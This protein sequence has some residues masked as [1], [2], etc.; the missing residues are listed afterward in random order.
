MSWMDF[1]PYTNFHEIN[2]DWLI[3]TMQELIKSWNEYKA[4]M[5]L[6]FS[7]LSD[8]FSALKTYVNT[9]FDELDITSEI[10][11]IISTY[12]EDGTMTSIL[13]S[14]FK[15]YLGV[16]AVNSNADMTDPEKVYVISTD[17]DGY[18]WFWDGTQFIKSSIAY[19]SPLNSLS[20]STAVPADL[21][22]VYRQVVR[23]PSNAISTT[24][25]T[26]DTD[27]GIIV[28]DFSVG[29]TARLQLA[30]NY[31]ISVDALSF[32]ERH[33]QTDTFTDWHTINDD[34][35]KFLSTGAPTDMNDLYQKVAAF[36]TSELANLTNI[37]PTNYGFI[38]ADFSVQNGRRAQFAFDFASATR[39][40]CIYFRTFSSNNW[41][42]W[43]NINAFVWGER[44]MEADLSTVNKEGSFYWFT[45]EAAN[46]A[47]SP[48]PKIA[49]I[50]TMTV[51]PDGRA[52]Q[53]VTSWGTRWGSVKAIRNRQASSG[54][55]PA[56][57]VIRDKE[58]IPG[59]GLT[60]IGD[61]MSCGYIQSSNSAGDDFYEQSWPAYYARR[62][63][64]PFYTA[65]AS[66][67]STVN[68]LSE[69]SD[70][71]ISK[72]RR[73]PKTQLYAVGLGIN[74]YNQGVTQA[75]FEANYK[76][77]LDAIFEKNPNAIVF[78]LYHARTNAAAY[79]TYVAN[80]VNAYPSNRVF[81]IDRVNYM[82]TGIINNFL[83][84]GHYSARGY[85]LMGEDFDEQVSLILND[86]PELFNYD[87]SK[88][89]E[90]DAFVRGGYPYPY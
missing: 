3:H 64:I 49:G 70:A 16:R 26:P 85:E 46:I 5:D 10:I 13:E 71:G 67:Y 20:F 60:V 87:Y 72:F 34:V 37:P 47:D 79:N 50:F 25:N 41:S 55:W 35:L 40:Y 58:D 21:D 83:L 90:S 44:V 8:E 31:S 68:F 63:G 27:T 14:V 82:Q 36:S 24:A 23:V 75:S 7:N 1:F 54:E 59:L 38:I 4:E 22:D 9:Y 61:S 62:K 89:I 76:L 51:S 74:D 2:A 78:C 29:N 66:G 52:Q 11:T 73:F 45:S 6:N 56:W 28:L 33:T 69:N 77:I 18:L 81:I 57:T 15:D 48:F 12:I 53:T 17:P 30:F 39:S 32:W 42:Q 80:V 88:A 43:T 19:N 86:H 84:Y 65:G